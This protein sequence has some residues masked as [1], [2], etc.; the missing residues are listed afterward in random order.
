MTENLATIYPIYPLSLHR[1]AWLILEFARR[2][3]AFRACAF[4]E[5]EDDQAA[6]LTP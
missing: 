4:R 2:T 6:R 3:S 1:A 5:Q